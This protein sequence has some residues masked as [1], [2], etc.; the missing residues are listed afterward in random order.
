RADAVAPDPEQT[1]HGARRRHRLRTEDR[2]SERVPIDRHGEAAPGGRVAQNRVRLAVAIADLE[3]EKAVG[4]RR[5]AHEAERA[6]GRGTGIS[7]GWPDELHQVGFV[8]EQEVERGVRVSREPPDHGYRSSVR[9]LHGIE[10]EE[11]APL[12]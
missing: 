5:E 11:T 8:A 6:V 4:R 12:P 7:R 3:A 2:A 1:G 10:P 9:G